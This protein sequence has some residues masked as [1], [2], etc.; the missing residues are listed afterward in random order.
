MDRLEYLVQE[1]KEYPEYLEEIK[2]ILDNKPGKLNKLDKDSNTILMRASWSSGISSSLDTV[3]LLLEYNPDLEIKSESGYTALCYTIEDMYDGS[4]IET[5]ELLLK[6]GAD[7]NNTDINGRTVLMNIIINDFLFD[8]KIIKYLLE[9]TKINLDIKDNT[10]LTA[11][12]H[13]IKKNLL[14]IA[15]LIQEY[16]DDGLLVK[17]ALD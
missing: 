5:V 13:A 7:I 2:Y 17:C 3:K 14:D 8:K 16:Q 11:Y 1:T 6:H 10:G 9:N 4:T 15:K 12:D